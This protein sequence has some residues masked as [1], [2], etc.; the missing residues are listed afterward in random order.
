M[1]NDSP[2]SL[3]VIGHLEELRRRIFTCLLYL[4]AGTVIGLMAAKP[5]IELLKIP[6]H[7]LI[8]EFILLKPTDVIAVYMRVAVAAGLIFA[9]PLMLRE[10]W[11]FV[12]PAVPDGPKV[13]WWAWIAVAA[14]L[15]AAGTLFAYRVLA[16]AALELLL[17]LSRELAAP[18]ISLNFYISFVVAVLGLGGAVFE[19]PVLIAL[20]TRLG[21]VT[22][23]LLV[24]KWREAV[25][26]LL[27]AAA[28]L[29]PTTDVFNMLLF[30]LP[31]LVLYAAGIGVSALV[32]RG[33]KKLPGEEA[34]FHET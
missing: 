6:A 15:F 28:V 26:G 24:R 17:R 18:M 14:L 12:K 32:L 33:R 5:L 21:L 1:E 34:Y 2:G 13:A 11:L 31:M 20:L 22:P 25:F 3:S 30:V 7:G 8:P 29:T 4:A 10:A 23:G 9:G 19:I 27:A 16:P